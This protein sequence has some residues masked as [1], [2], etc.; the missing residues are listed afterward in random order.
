[1]VLKARSRLT[2]CRVVG[3]LK[4]RF[5][6][7]SKAFE[8]SRYLVVRKMLEDKFS[9]LFSEFPWYAPR[10]GVGTGLEELSD[11]EWNAVLAIADFEQRLNIAPDH[12]SRSEDD[13][14]LARG[15]VRAVNRRDW[16]DLLSYISNRYK[17]IQLYDMRGGDMKRFLKELLNYPLDSIAGA[18]LVELRN[19][20]GQARLVL[21]LKS[22][23]G[24]Q[25]R[26]HLSLHREQAGGRGVLRIWG[27]AE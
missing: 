6:E 22:K 9:E 2:R 20:H 23:S 14:L 15:F 4:H 24:L 16:I 12:P 17:D 5:F 19:V 11:W 7:V 25:K 21:N 27:A 1:M 26:F 3:Q 18:E 13:V 8:N 10:E